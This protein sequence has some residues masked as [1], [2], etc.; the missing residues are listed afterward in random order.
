MCI[1]MCIYFIYI[2]TRIDNIYIYTNHISYMDM[3][4]IS[5][6]VVHLFVSSNLIG[7]TLKSK[8]NPCFSNRFLRFKVE[9]ISPAVFSHRIHNGKPVGD[10]E[11]VLSEPSFFG[12]DSNK[13]GMVGFDRISKP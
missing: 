4:Y 3:L 9:E 1:Y 5:N 11:T 7:E 12:G 13:S 6:T 2:Y 8:E 10:R